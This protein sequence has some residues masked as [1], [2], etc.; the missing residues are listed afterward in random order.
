MEKL[1]FRAEGSAV[2]AVYTE[3]ERRSPSPPFRA[4][5]CAGHEVFRRGRDVYRRVVIARH[6]STETEQNYSS[7]AREVEATAS[8]SV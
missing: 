5:F 8:H 3:S 1:R 7:L 6:V 2:F 4:P